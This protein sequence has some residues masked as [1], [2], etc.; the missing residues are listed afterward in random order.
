[1][2]DVDEHAH[3]WQDAIRELAAME[4]PSASDGERRAAEFIADRLRALGCDA[5]VEEERA[6]GG[7]W[8]PIGLVNALA[9]ASGALT[10]R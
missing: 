3:D 9:A 5:T 6:H 10:L 2:I 7:Y 1:M 4:R 8:W